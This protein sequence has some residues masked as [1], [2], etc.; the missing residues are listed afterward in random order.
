MIA[1][2]GEGCGFLYCLYCT[3]FRWPRL[4]R[5][6]GTLDLLF[7]LQAMGILGWLIGYAI[8]LALWYFEIDIGI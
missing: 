1:L 7:W 5:E 6:Q 4:R 8:D 2:I 3:I